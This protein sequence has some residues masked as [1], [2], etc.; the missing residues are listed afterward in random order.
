[1]INCGSGSKKTIAETLETLKKHLNIQT[2]IV[3]NGQKKI[4]DPEFY[5]ADLTE[6]QKYNWVPKIH[7]EDGFTEYAEWFKLK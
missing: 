1:M 4:G 2:Q 6:T 7:L 3:F 5:W